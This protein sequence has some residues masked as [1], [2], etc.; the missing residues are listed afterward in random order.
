MSAI[1][2]IR[3]L[4]GLAVAA[5][6][7][8]AVASAPPPRP[9]APPSYRLSGPCTHDNLTI[10]FIHGADQVKG[11]KILTLD[12]ALAQKKVIVH[13]TRNVN[14]LAIENVSPNE[15]VFVQAGDIVKGGQQDRTIAYDLLVPPKS[16]RLPLA[17]FC[18][19]RGR[20]SRRGGENV[21]RF[22]RSYNCL[23]GNGLK[24]AARKD[25][26]QEK[27]WLEVTK[28]Q[29]DLGAKLTTEVRSKTSASSLQL[30]LENKKLQEA[31]NAY[32]KKL[33]A[34]PARERDV[35]G[36]AVVIN[37]KVNSADVYASAEL[38]RK[39]W[40]KLLKG[41]AVEAVAEKSDK[42]FA[43]VGVEA[44]RTFLG[45]PARG[46]RSERAVG[47]LRELQQETDKV[48][49]FETRSASSSLR[50]SYLAK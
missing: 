11:K 39:L 21:A 13:E 32:V 46:K 50:R 17:A 19:E 15:E 6:T 10:F 25:A 30:A 44:V 49:L 29:K 27:V 48:I 40:P 18:V 35:I 8:L 31:S 16:G 23:V 9:P 5:V 2:R 42:K 36:Y 43:P 45:S 12:E 20:W 24:I 14:Q 33:A 38:F 22:G 47:K 41:N 3:V 37:G 28:A 4:A 1:A 34:A 26:S 7:G